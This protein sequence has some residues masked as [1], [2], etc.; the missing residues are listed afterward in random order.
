MALL[1]FLLVTAARSAGEAGGGL[2]S[3]D[4]HDD[5]VRV[6][7][8]LQA[9]REALEA[10]LVESRRRVSE[11]GELMTSSRELR[12]EFIARSDVLLM[13]AGLVAMQGP[14]LR[15]TLAD[16][17][18]PPDAPANPGNYIV[19]DYDLRVLVNA[20]WAGGAEAI[21]V[22]GERLTVMSAIRCVGTTV[23]VNSKR[24]SSPFVI[25]AVGDGAALDAALASDTDA[26]ALT[27]EQVQA[28]GLTYHAE[29]AGNLYLPAYP[30]RLHPAVLTPTAGAG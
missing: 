20:L 16:N 11:V 4:G 12:D 13:E 29:R 21:A 5:L 9:K 10:E 6:V 8:Q 7:Q 1:G 3:G 14:G 15:V 23:L 22:N 17:G 2:I 28:F 30:D 19:H 18:D 26:L 25:E 27:T 24:V